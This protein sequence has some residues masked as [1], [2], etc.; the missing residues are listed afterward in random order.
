AP[1]CPGAID[2]RKLAQRFVASWDE[3]V[4]AEAGAEG[5][6]AIETEP[7]DL[8]RSDADPIGSGSLEV[9]PRDEHRS[10]VDTE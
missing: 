3:R 8:K 2:Y 9:Q 10:S 6:A 5:D 7:L 4:R 1:W